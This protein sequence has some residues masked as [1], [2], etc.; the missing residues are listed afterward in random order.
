MRA[1][2]E[3]LNPKKRGSFDIAFSGFFS[4]RNY[5]QTG[6]E[7]IRLRDGLAVNERKARI[8]RYRFFDALNISITLDLYTAS[9][10]NTL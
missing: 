5:T 8:L 10:I 6:S 7:T 3:K 2:K 9:N 4:I 1:N